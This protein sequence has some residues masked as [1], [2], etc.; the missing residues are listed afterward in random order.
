MEQRIQI[1]LSIQQT[2]DCVRQFHDAF[3]I[4]NNF[5]PTAIIPQRE[6]ELRLR[7]MQEENDE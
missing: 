3:L 5:A 1:P 7:L 2:I 4:E 6:F